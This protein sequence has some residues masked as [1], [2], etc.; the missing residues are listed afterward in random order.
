MCES[1]EYV[2]TCP[3]L[4]AS[5]RGVCVYPVDLYMREHVFMCTYMSE[6][7]PCCFLL[8]LHIAGDACVCPVVCM[9]VL[10]RVCVLQ[11]PQVTAAR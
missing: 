4:Y 3:C 7:M 8:P 11:M 9:N 6:A 10:T 2:C 1:R 5:V